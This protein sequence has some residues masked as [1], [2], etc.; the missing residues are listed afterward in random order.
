M[1]NRITAIPSSASPDKPEQQAQ[2]ELGRDHR[3]DHH[4]NH[5]ARADRHADD[6]HDAQTHL[7]PGQVRG[8]G[9]HRRRDRAQPLQRATGDDFVD[10][11]RF[12]GNNAATAKDEQSGDDY[13]FAPKAVR[14]KTEG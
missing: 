4:R 9:H 8:Q 6:R 10:A 5:E 12:R 11:L 2:A 3:S 1:T 7:F 14:Q 13:G